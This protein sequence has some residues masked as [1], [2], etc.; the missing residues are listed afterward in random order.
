MGKSEEHLCQI[1]III[2]YCVFILLGF[3][4]LIIC[5]NLEPQFYTD[6]EKFNSIFQMN[7]DDL[8]NIKAYE[9]NKFNLELMEHLSLLF[10]KFAR[11]PYE[12]DSY[13]KRFLNFDIINYGSKSDDN[14]FFTFKNDS[15]KTVIISFPGTLTIPQLLDEAFGSSLISFGESKQILIGQ[16]FGKRA[17]NLLELIFNDELETLIKNNYQIISTGHS[18]GGA[19]AQSFMYFALS[20]GKINRTNC[21]MTITF[22]QPKVGNKFFSSYLDN[23]TFLNLRFVNKNDIVSKIPFCTGLFNHIK[24]FFNKLSDDKIYFHT[25]KEF[26]QHNIN[27][28]PTI[29]FIF[30]SIVDALVFFFKLLLLLIPIY[31]I[32]YYFLSIFCLF[33]DINNCSNKSIKYLSIVNVFLTFFI[34]FIITNIYDFSK[35]STKTSIICRIFIFLIIYLGIL[36]SIIFIFSITSFFIYS[37]NCSCKCDDEETKIFSNYCNCKTICN[38][39]LFICSGLYKAFTYFRNFD[40]HMRYQY[41]NDNQNKYI[42]MYSIDKVEINSILER[43]RE[44]YKK[45]IAIL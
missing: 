16:Y 41:S 12:K 2:F 9:N 22:G 38:F 19:M 20:K 6:E 44:V 25:E 43:N 13:S 8:L 35:Y 17:E 40:P 14:Y 3:Y 36:I 24:Y 1:I 23:N 31:Y 29:I 37:F 11:Y 30:I 42:N 18:L 21:P 28:F 27:N 10:A 45:D 33:L 34:Y 4:F 7:E 39:I 15:L 5:F 32:G 26:I